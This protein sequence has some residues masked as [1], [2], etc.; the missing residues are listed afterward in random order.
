MWLKDPDHDVADTSL[1]SGE[2]RNSQLKHKCSRRILRPIPNSTMPP[3]IS[4]DL[5]SFFPKN[6]PRY[7]PISE[8]PNVTVPIMATGATMDRFRSAKLIPTANESMLVAMD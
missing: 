5:P 8:T 4:A 3:M 1:F 6:L 2:K 7:N